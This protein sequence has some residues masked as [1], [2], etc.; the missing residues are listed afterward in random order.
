M[1][2]I[3]DRVRITAKGRKVGLDRGYVMIPTEMEFTVKGVH[4]S[5]RTLQI[6]ARGH[7]WPASCW[8]KI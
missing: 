4:G 3:G 7:W 1:F 6:F 2:A 8:E 5:G